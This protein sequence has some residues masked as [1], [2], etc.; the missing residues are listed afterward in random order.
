MVSRDHE[1]V[2][3]V[4]VMLSALFG[5][6]VLRGRGRQAGGRDG[7]NWAWRLTVAGVLVCGVSELY[8]GKM[9]V[10]SRIGLY[11]GAPAKFIAELGLD[12]LTFV[13]ICEVPSQMLWPKEPSRRSAYIVFSGTWCVSLSI[14]SLY[15]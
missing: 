5:M 1:E 14:V 4:M 9:V 8:E 2:F 6:E 7:V 12:G 11:G 13:F 10:A 3:H 15:S